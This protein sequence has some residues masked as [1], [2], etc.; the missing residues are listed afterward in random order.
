MAENAQ[1]KSAGSRKNHLLVAACLSLAPL[2]VAAA[3]L[4]WPDRIDAVFLGLFV[5][6]LVP[7]L[8]RFLKRVKTP[9]GIEIEFIRRL[10]RVCAEVG[11]GERVYKVA[12][13]TVEKQRSDLFRHWILGLGSGDLVVTTSGAQ[14][15]RFLLPNVLFAGRKVDRI[16]GM[17]KR[18]QVV[19]TPG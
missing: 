4:V 16:A 18:M 8:G 7:W 3:H 14:V 12:G 11:G 17:L 13:W 1:D 10:D 5:L 9:W 2:A 6:A 19:A 15:E